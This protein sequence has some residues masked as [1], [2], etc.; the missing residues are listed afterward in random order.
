MFRILATLRFLRGTPFDPF[1]RTHERQL[2]RQLIVDYEALLKDIAARLSVS[3]HAVAVEL[4]SVP[5]KIKGYGFIKLRNLESA[6]QEEAALIERF[7][8]TI[9]PLPLAA[10]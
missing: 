6:K 7:H 3:N 8:A 10:E 1:G 9:P 4:A 5:Q 2:E